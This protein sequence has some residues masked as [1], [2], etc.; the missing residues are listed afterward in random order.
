MKDTY[1]AT[2]IGGA[3]A[4]V[5]PLRRFCCILIGACSSQVH[6]AVFYFEAETD[7][8][9]L[10]LQRRRWLNGTNAGYLHIMLN[11]RWNLQ[12]GIGPSSHLINCSSYLGGRLPR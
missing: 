3:Y 6:D 12:T 5:L 1:L 8:R 4:G 2:V 10:V 9:S 11:V 7:L